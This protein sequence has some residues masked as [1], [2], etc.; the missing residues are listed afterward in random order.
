M[1]SAS[2][3][4][5]NKK[6][7]R[8]VEI[9]ALLLLLFC[10]SFCPSQAHADVSSNPC[11][12]K[13]TGPDR[14]NSLDCEEW[15]GWLISRTVPIAIPLVISLLFLIPGY[16]VLLCGRYICNCFGSSR[17][18]PGHCCCGGS[19]LDVLSEPE[20]IMMYDRCG[21]R[22]V[23]LL[24][25][26][27]AILGLVIIIISFVGGGKV[28]SAAG[29]ATDGVGDGIDFMLDLVDQTLEGIRDPSDG[30]YPPGFSKGNFD[31]VIDTLSDLNHDIR[32]QVGL[33]D[34]YLQSYSVIPAYVAA[35]PALL[36]AFPLLFAICNI[37]T[38]GPLSI[39]CC[40]FHI[41]FIFMLVATIFAIMLIPIDLVCGELYQQ[42]DGK[43]G[44]FQWY[45]IPE[46][47][48]QSPFKDILDNIDEMELDASNDACQS[49]L[50]FCSTSTTYNSGDPQRMFT[51][52][53]TAAIDCADLHTVKGT[54]ETMLIKTGAPETCGGNPSLCT[55][56]YCANNCDNPNT[57][58]ASADAVDFLNIGIRVLD[59]FDNIIRPW[60][61]CDRLI[62]KAL[63][64]GPL[65][66]C[67]GIG[68]GLKMICAGSYMSAF[69]LIFCVVLCFL[70]QKRF[71]SQDDALKKID[72][73]S[74]SSIEMGVYNQH[75]NNRPPPFS[76]GVPLQYND[77]PS[78]TP[79]LPYREDAWMGGGGFAENGGFGG[80]PQPDAYSNP[81]NT[82]SPE[83]NNAAPD[84]KQPEPHQSAEDPGE[85]LQPLS[86]QSSSGFL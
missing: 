6:D 74:P 29:E 54:M 7:Q 9:L 83:A 23:K 81:Q 1:I 34:K 35:L 73:A 10:F 11:T 52:N 58:S 12:S 15:Q 64:S 2:Q 18:R 43:P 60:L 4:C 69:G 30:S 19:E 37:R 13:W 59:T 33:Y 84:K 51:C 65:Q 22:T 32:D 62:N 67:D 82:P 66:I 71:V 61:N 36:M 75:H 80:K 47:E 48:Y 27:S 85:L 76:T 39:V 38:C 21:I 31:S 53:L 14:H 49:L 24:A 3:G 17:M 44:V 68:G 57:K 56:P 26:L 78:T 77:A 46:C 20:K 16:C 72:G 25:L 63:E 45:V 5:R 28:A 86:R 8:Q 79:M 42:L 40:S 55:I 70:G 41:Q 50:E